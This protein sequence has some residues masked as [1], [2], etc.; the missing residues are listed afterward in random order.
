M[1]LS[2]DLMV[3]SEELEING[4]YYLHSLRGARKIKYVRPFNKIHRSMADDPAQRDLWFIFAPPCEV[5]RW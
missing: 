1:K 2:K 4:L 3:Q 5:T